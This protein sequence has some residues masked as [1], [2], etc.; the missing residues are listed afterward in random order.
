MEHDTTE[1]DLFIRESIDTVET[2][3]AATGSD[4]QNLLVSLLVMNIGVDWTVAV[5]EAAAYA[6][7]FEAVG[8]DVT[9]NPRDT[10]AEEIIRVDRDR[11]VKNLSLMEN[12]R[13]EVL[14]VETDEES[15]LTGRPIHESIADLP[16]EAV[17]GAITRREEFIMPEEIPSSTPE[18]MSSCLL[19]LMSF[20]TFW[21][22]CLA[23]AGD[24]LDLNRK[25]RP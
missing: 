25:Q 6:E 15:L 23:P 2:V 24:V 11:T 1:S 18:T 3:I 13:A 7:V 9:I 12:Q 19:L 4:E 22:S 14:E 8:V 17:I 10:T 21:A 5:V 20:L 16:T